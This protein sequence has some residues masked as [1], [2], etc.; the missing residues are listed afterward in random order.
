LVAI[1]ERLQAA[2]DRLRSLQQGGLWRGFPTLAGQSDVWVSGF[3]A[4]H[5]SGVE[6]VTFDAAPTIAALLETGATDG[7]WGY[8]GDVPVDADSTAWCAMAV[9]GDNAAAATLI[10]ARRVLED[11]RHGNG[12]ATYLPESG[13]V[14]FIEASSAA[15]VTG[16]T[17]A[18]PDVT[19]AVLLAGVP[20][21]EADSEPVLRHLVASQTGAGFIDSYWWRGPFYG[22]AL[23]LRALNARGR[24]LEPDG[25]ATMYEGL[26]GKQLADGGFG[27]GASPNM[28]PFTTAL[29]LEALCRLAH[30]D[31]EGLRHRAADAL[32]AV[33]GDDG[34]WSGDFILRIPAPD[35]IYPRHVDEWS[36]G[37][38]GGNSFVPDV[39]GLF[40]TAVAAYA[41]DLWQRGPAPG[42]GYEPVT[43]E[44]VDRVDEAIVR[45]PN[46]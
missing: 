5:L 4:S 21:D 34:G 45:I 35:V 3:V 31:D 10:E 12:F 11:H 16:W 33:Q 40:A 24:R 7:G 44:Q 17:A 18:H 13:I 26:A 39:D 2:L 30:L 23:A 25:E 22:S 6:S 15:R 28:D 36:R 32:V 41:L 37:T 38:G 14:K 43:P 46:S 1:V 29:G 9:A 42:D 27:L 20:A 19:A 8:G